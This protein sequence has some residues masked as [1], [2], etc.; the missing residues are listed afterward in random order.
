MLVAPAQPPN[1]GTVSVSLDGATWLVDAS[2]LHGEPLRLERAGETEVAHPAWGVRARS[3]GA[4]WLVRWR[5][6]HRPDGLDC[7][8]DTLDG[9]AADFARLHEATRAWSPFNYSLY[10]RTLRGDRVLGTAFGRHVEIDAEGRASEAPLDPAARR[11]LLAEAGI[12][13]ELA[14]R[15]PEDV[16]LPPP[17]GA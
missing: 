8:I 13:D 10:L 14:A 17:P 2:I 12:S 16:P 3:E 9:S 5:P 4:K 6:Q 1:H 15:M 7:R 11:R